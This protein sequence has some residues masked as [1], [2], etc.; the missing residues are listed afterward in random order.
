MLTVV[1]SLFDDN[2]DPIREGTIHLY[3]DQN[4]FLAVFTTDR[5][6]NFNVNLKSPLPPQL[7]FRQCQEKSMLADLDGI[8]EQLRKDMAFLKGRTEVAEITYL[9]VAEIVNSTMNVGQLTLS[10]PYP[11]EQV[12]LSYWFNLGSTVAHTFLLKG[13]DSIKHKISSS[14]E[15]TSADVQAAY[16]FGSV[17]LTAENTF[18]MLTNGICPIYFKRSVDGFLLAEINWDPYNFDKLGSLP[19]TKLLFDDGVSKSNPPLVRLELQY[20]KTLHASSL[21]ED[22][23]PVRISTP[24]SPDFLTEL[25]AANSAIGVLGET[26]YHLGIG[27]VYGAKY[28]QDVHDYL[29]GTVLGELLIPHCQFI[30]KITFDIGD[31]VIMKGVLDA[32]ALNINGIGQLIVDTVAAMNPFTYKPRRVMHDEHYFAKIQRQGYDVIRRAVHEY[33]SKYRKRVLRDW[34]AIHLFYADRHRS[35]PYYRPWNNEDVLTAGY[36]DTYEIGGFPRQYVP[37]RTKFRETDPA[38]KAMPWIARDPNGPSETDFFW[39]ELDLTYF[40]YLVTIYHA[41]IHLSQSR[42]DANAPP[43]TDLNFS[44]ITINN[45]GAGLNGGITVEE[46]DLQESVLKTLCDFP[47]EKYALINMAGVYPGLSRRLQEATPQFIQ[48]KLDPQQQIY[49]SGVI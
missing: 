45:Y 20:R 4:K 21:D 18:K 36:I 49:V 29:Q 11:K 42:S 10:S 40:I 9:V 25:R 31:S 38:V 2:H 6:G 13:L 22:K 14:A 12:P 35:F 1:G 41:W 32:S 37:E 34:N 8:S 28:A 23:E 17:P 33:L 46:A 26:V 3:T 27:H 39:I 16:G 44:P 43:L 5:E 7:I 15:Y 47:A 19:N 24:D 48:N 30:R